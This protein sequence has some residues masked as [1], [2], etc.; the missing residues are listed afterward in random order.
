MTSASFRERLLAKETLIGTFVKTP[1]PIICE[2]LGLTELDAVCLDAEHA[3]FGRLEL[4]SAVQALRAAHMPA[5]IRVAANAPEYILQALD[6]GAAGVVVPHVNTPEQAAAA[7]KS[8]G[9][10]EGGRG[11]AG[12]PRAAGYST[13]PMAQHLAES[14]AET[15]VIV[16]I[17]EPAAVQAIDEI[18]AV[19]G[20]DCLFIG[21]IDLTVA[22]KAHSPNDAAVISAVEKVCR[23]GRDFGKPIGMFVPD[24]NEAK[25]WIDQGASLFL[26]GSD[27]AF[28]LQGAAA[29]ISSVKS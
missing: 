18:C 6:C 1:A 28:V 25:H 27:H 11:Y 8:A 7:V 19:D 9:F 4:D 13:K 16:Q 29:L 17:E 2:V 14:K 15:T 12:S 26:L 10:G 23:A 3:P 24:S 21:R 20:I 22:L 5:L